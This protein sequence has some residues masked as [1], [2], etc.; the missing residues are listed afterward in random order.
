MGKKRAVKVLVVHG[1][2]LNMLGRRETD[3][4]GTATLDSIV[5]GLRETGRSLGLDVDSFQSNS[6]GEIVSAIQ[7]ART[8]YAAILI[9]PAA[10][11]HT[12]IA[13]RDA[14]L[15]F[16]GP[17]V[18]VHLSNIHRREEFRHR[19]LIADVA[20]GQVTG[21]GAA[22]YTLGLQALAGLLEAE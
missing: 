9:N 17:I 7:S 13:I 1:P 15:A 10:Y 12:S 18:E 16:D 19:S 14:L 4:Y 20:A 8:E 22:S 11:T 3:V 5:A 6:E 21:F 2:N